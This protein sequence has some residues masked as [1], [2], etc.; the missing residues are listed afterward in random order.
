M[1]TSGQPTHEPSIYLRPKR[2]SRIYFTYA[3]SPL[4][5]QLYEHEF[6]KRS[7]RARA[8]ASSFYRGLLRGMM[9]GISQ[10]SRPDFTPNQ[11]PPDYQIR[12]FSDQRVMD[13]QEIDEEPCVAIMYIYI[14]IYIYIYVSHSRMRSHSR[15]LFNRF[16]RLLRYSWR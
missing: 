6:P 10:I 1:V 11:F 12:L 3:L 13:R 2:N 7:Q 5:F 14:Y 16:N 9:R 15:I 4:Y 8:N